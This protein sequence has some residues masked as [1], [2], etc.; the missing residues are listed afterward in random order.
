MEKVDLK[1]KKILFQLDIDSRQSFSKIGRKVGLRKELIAYRV[2][3][4]QEK[5]IIKNFFT[6]IDPSAL[7]YSLPR[8]YLKFQY[9]TP[10]TKDEII[11]YF[12]KSKYV[13]FVHS[14]EG[15]YDLSLVMIVKN[16]IDFNNFWEKTMIRYRDYFSNHFFS[17]LIRESIYR[18]SFFFD[19]NSTERFDRSK[20]VVFGRGKNAN[21]DDLDFKILRIITPNARIPTKYIANKLNT[22]TITINSRTNKLKQ[23]GVI[24]GFKVDVDLTKLGYHF[25]KA[26]VTLKDPRKYEKIFK[27]I[28][29]NPYLNHILK[30]IGY[31]DLELLFYLKSINQL[32]DIM[33]DLSVKFPGAIKDYRYFRV[34]KTYKWNYMPEI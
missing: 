29:M 17:I 34:I 12:L 1:D 9:A 10:E 13:G 19:N 20:L 33:R 15:H 22:T 27:K 30:S 32:H 23:I 14:G 18:Y 4:L 31:V 3:R 7:G 26:D 6:V 24:K 8:F 2:K 28:E 25:Y 16:I 11:N 5:G 21:I